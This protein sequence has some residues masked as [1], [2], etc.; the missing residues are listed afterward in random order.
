MWRKGVHLLKR[1]LVSSSLVRTSTNPHGKTLVS[2]HIRPTFLMVNLLSI[3]T[4]AYQGT[5]MR[6]DSYEPSRRTKPSKRCNYSN[7]GCECRKPGPDI[8]NR[9]PEFP[10]YFTIRKCSTTE[11]RVTLNLFYEKD[12]AICYPDTTHFVRIDV[13][14]DLWVRSIHC[15]STS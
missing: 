6:N 3:P 5:P 4:W 15:I 1:P 10:L 8:V 9:T 7:V 14:H 2:C 11:I 12:G 13:G